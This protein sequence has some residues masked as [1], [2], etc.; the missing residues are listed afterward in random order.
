MGV[1]LVFEDGSRTGMLWLFI[2]TS[3][4]IAARI[5]N[6]RQKLTFTGIGVIG[7][8]CLSIS[9][10]VIFGPVDN[11]LSSAL[12][13]YERLLHGDSARLDM[14]TSGLRQADAC[15]PIGCGFGAT[16][17]D[18][19]EMV[20][21][22]AYLGA[23]GDIGIIGL[24]GFVLISI[25][26]FFAFYLKS[27][28]VHKTGFGSVSYVSLAALLGSAGFVFNENL[29]SF[30]TEMSEWGL[31]FIMFSFFLVKAKDNLKIISRNRLYGKPCID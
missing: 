17:S 16:V 20:V 24:S 6:I 1:F 30:R 11:V 5:V 15:L 19:Y 4:L 10:L 22:N 26:P 12:L 21:H 18:T 28:R 3:I 8:C 29:H 23:I 7:F 14:L 25:T 13:G 27:Q 9:Y 2:S 31:F